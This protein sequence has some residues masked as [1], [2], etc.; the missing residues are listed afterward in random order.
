MLAVFSLVF[1]LG[2]FFFEGDGMSRTALLIQAWSIEHFLISTTM[3]VVG[4]FAV[5]SWNSIFPDR[6]DILI[7]SPLPV[8]VRTLFLAKIAATATS[9]G[10]AILAAEHFLGIELALSIER[11]KL[12]GIVASPL[13]VGLLG[14][15]TCC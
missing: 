3:L 12:V 14:D 15:E 2:A 4:L 1:S 8:S 13:L 9:L 7:L 11:R 6:R 10:L 5:L